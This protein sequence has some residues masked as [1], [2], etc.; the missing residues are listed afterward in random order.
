MGA[1]Q[2]SQLS[3]LEGLQVSRVHHGS[4]AFESGL[5][6]FFDFIVQVDTVALDGDN[7]SFFYDYVKKNENKPIK[8][9]VF[10]LRC[11]NE[12]ECIVT[13]RDWSGNRANGILGFNVSWE[14]ADKA[15]ES[16]WHITHVAPNSPAHKADLMATRDFLLGMQMPADFS[17]MT[18][19]KDSSEF[20]TRLEEWRM[21][22]EAIAIQKPGSKGSLLLLAFDSMA[23][24]I[25]EIIVEIS[26]PHESLGLEVAN[27]YL[28]VVPPTPGSHAIPRLTRCVVTRPAN[29]A[30]APPAAATPDQVAAAA[31]QAAAPAIPALPPAMAPP[32]FPQPPAS[33]HQQQQQQP[34]LGLVAT[35]F[36]GP[37][38]A[39]QQQHQLIPPALPTLPTFPAP[40]PPPVVGAPPPFRVGVGAPYASPP[41]S[42]P[43]M[44]SALPPFP[45]MQQQPHHH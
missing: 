6:P 36:A 18:V 17:T 7:Y 4:P 10:N 30:P 23:N 1:E 9:R 11:R 41:P 15:I 19:F 38:P 27:G 13:P 32:S 40:L 28:H 24:Q 31:P 25:K 35:G 21:V 33:Q 43:P 42:L 20:H 29:S 5:V 8:L 22:Q 37:V 16:T 3:M 26:S 2:S 12:R 14:S 45:S 34:P 44:P 39:A